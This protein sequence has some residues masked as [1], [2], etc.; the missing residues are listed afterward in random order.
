M[1]RAL[2]WSS[3]SEEKK[4]G[5]MSIAELMRSAANSLAMGGPGKWAKGDFY[6]GPG[7]CA[8]GVIAQ[9]MTGHRV[10]IEGYR[11]AEK[12]LVKTLK[13]MHPELT[14]DTI[15]DLNDDPAV[16]FEDV[17]AAF[18]KTALHYEEMVE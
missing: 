18:E 13:D 10:N 15:P 9:V 3:T 4:H 5:T 7:A 6:V 11:N 17:L 1:S 16:T 12:M 8:L 14:A 2:Y